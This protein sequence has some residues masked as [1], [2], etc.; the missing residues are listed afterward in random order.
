MARSIIMCLILQSVTDCAHVYDIKYQV[1]CIQSNLFDQTIDH[2]YDP[3]SVSLKNAIPSM[4]NGMKHSLYWPRSFYS[5]TS[6]LHHENI[7]YDS[8]LYL[9]VEWYTVFQNESFASHQIYKYPISQQFY[10]DNFHLFWQ[11]YIPI[12]VLIVDL[13]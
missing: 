5:Q 10:N 8:R 4:L 11:M 9:D 3:L 6:E 1:R 13:Y 12:V 7:S 2:W